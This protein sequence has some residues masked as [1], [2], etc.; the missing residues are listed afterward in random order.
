MS[1]V[2]EPKEKKHYFVETHAGTHD[3]WATSAAK[4]ISNIRFRLF[5][6]QCG[7]STIYWKVR[8]DKQ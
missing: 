2:K 4:A 5:G 1:K 7:V 8:E 6:G 3:T